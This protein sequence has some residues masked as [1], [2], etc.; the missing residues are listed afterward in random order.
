MRRTRWKWDYMIFDNVNKTWKENV[1]HFSKIKFQKKLIKIFF[2]CRLGAKWDIFS[3]HPC[4]A[5]TFYKNFIFCINNI[6][7]DFPLHFTTSFHSPHLAFEA[8]SPN[9]WLKPLWNQIWTFKPPDLMY[10]FFE[11]LNP[12]KSLENFLFCEFKI[13]SLGRLW[14]HCEKCSLGKVAQLVRPSVKATRKT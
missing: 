5:L 14:F 13:V 4:S 12:Y 1:N 2:Q 3:W 9:M 7:S 8:A 11:F 10:I 6:S